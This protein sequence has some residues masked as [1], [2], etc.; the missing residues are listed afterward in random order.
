MGFRDGFR[1]SKSEVL[2]LDPG[3]R[4]D[5]KGDLFAAVQTGT[6]GKLMGML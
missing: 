2:L 5:I 6:G 3:Q 1:Y 4:N